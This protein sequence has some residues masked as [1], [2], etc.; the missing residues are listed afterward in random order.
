SQPGLIFRHQGKIRANPRAPADLK[1]LPPPRR[2]FF[3]NARYQREG[4][5]VGVETKRGCPMGCSYCADP[6]VRGRRLR[7]RPPLAVAR[8][9]A[10]LVAQGV[11]WFHLCDSEFNLSYNHAREVCQTIV[12]QGLGEQVHWYA[13]CAPTPMDRDLLGLMARAGCAGVNF[14][15]DSLCDA[16]LAR[17]GRRHRLDDVVQ[18]TAWLREMGLEFIYDLLLGGP[19]ETP[20]TVRE[21]VTRARGLELPLAGISLGVRVYPGTPLARGLIY[22]GERL[23]PHRPRS[24]HL[25]TFYVSPA[26][27]DDPVE[28]V[29]SLVS[30]DP[31]FLFLAKPQESGSYN[32]AG[33]AAL[34]DAIRKGARGAYWH[35]LAGQRKGETILKSSEA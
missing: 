27:G 2:R 25:P 21:T 34:A 33:D 14:G 5:M 11:T 32:Y 35:I 12:S 9:M 6:V 10:D 7:L 23:Q 13:Y 19:G 28:L 22:G 31:R 26:L 17:L 3:D 4:A 24:L 29:R 16:Q 8:E 30:G 1:Q 18:L 15:V 20:E